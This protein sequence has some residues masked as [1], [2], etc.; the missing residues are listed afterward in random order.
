MSFPEAV[1]IK[2][3]VTEADGVKTLRFSLKRKCLPGQFLMIWI[4][5]ID[6]IPMSLSY[7][8]NLKGI[9][10]RE[11]GEATRALCSLRPGDLLGVRGPYG[12][13]F[14][15]SKG[16]VLCVGG[17]NGIAPLMPA[18]EALR[19]DSVDFAI[20]AKTETELVFVERA[21]KCSNY[22]AISTD[23]GTKGLRGTVV[24]LAAKMLNKEKYDMMLAC[25]PEPMLSQL[26]DLCK[27]H[28]IDCQFSL[29]RFMKCGIGICGSCA[30]DGKRVCKEG[31]VFSR[32][33]LES[34]IEFGKFR[35][36]A[37]GMRIT[38]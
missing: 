1:T 37:S 13:G 26:F 8:D 27:K 14:S 28:D 5:G 6:E 29:E 11:V 3:V 38:F 22:V 10:V 15:L 24:E 18:A 21:K 30:I 20:G 4:P 31:P 19:R 9:T 35:R 16:R 32:R 12:R 36:D 33:E 7:I 23:D 17:G 34:L 25:G 2:E